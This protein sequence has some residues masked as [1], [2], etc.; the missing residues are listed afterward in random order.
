MTREKPKTIYLKDYKP[1]A[2]RIS[3]VDLHFDLTDNGAVVKSRLECSLADSDQSSPPL[4][5]NGKEFELISLAIDGRAL[6][7]NEYKTD[8]ET[9]TIFKA[10][11]SF[12]LEIVTRLKPH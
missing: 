7:E 9:L 11:S 10:P 1:P 12:S 2:Y 6:G 5:L 8:A 3:A 4:V